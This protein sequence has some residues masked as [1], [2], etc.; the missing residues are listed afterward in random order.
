M[1]AAVF[2]RLFRSCGPLLLIVLC[3]GQ[4]GCVQR[5][6]MIRSNPPGALVYVDDYEIG[7]TPIAS[8][9]TYYGQRKIRLVKEGYETLTVMQPVPAPW[10]QIP[11]LDFFS[12]NLV[13]GEIRD[14][15]TFTYQ[16]TPRRV[17]PT[18]QLLGRAENL[19]RGMQTIGT[20]GPLSPPPVGPTPAPLG[21]TA[22][23]PQSPGPAFPGGSP[24]GPLPDPLPMPQQGI[25]G[26]AIREMP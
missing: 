11:P 15:H 5:R 6:M 19:R 8:N 23:P 26:R 9:F 17:V 13:P 14:H 20:V 22:T 2:R 10:Y 25:G 16:L 7:T 3:A 1:L 4:I 18:D 24:A 21:P 12:E